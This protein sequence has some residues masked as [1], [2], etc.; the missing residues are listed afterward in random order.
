MALGV[1]EKQKDKARQV[2]QRSAKEAGFFAY[3]TTKLVYPALGN[4]GPQK[5]K[6]VADTPPDQNTQNGS[7]G[8][9]GGG[10]PEL[11]P[12]V[13]LLVSKLPKPET[14][15]QKS[16]RKKWL[17]AALKIF[18]LVFE[19]DPGDDELELKITLGPADSAN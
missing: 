10:G 3:G 18:D 15:W 19:E 4:L 5:A 9:G 16:G 17:E 14:M 8:N 13:Q 1:P 11:P 7:S 12:Y 2:F 6:D